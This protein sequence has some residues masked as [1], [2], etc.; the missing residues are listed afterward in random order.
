MTN[1]KETGGPAFP[2]SLPGM[3]DNGCDGMTLRDWF[4]GRAIALMMSRCQDQDGGWHPA[5][6]AAACYALADA[7]LEERRDH[8]PA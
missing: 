5:T 4:A 1:P 6:V 2:V 3:G 7:M 8:Q